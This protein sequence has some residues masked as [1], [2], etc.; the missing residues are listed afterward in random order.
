MGRYGSATR[1][2]RTN[3]GNLVKTRSHTLPRSICQRV[4][5]CLRRIE[6]Q[7]RLLTSIADNSTPNT[8]VRSH[9]TTSTTVAAGNDK[10]VRVCSSW[11]TAPAKNQIRRAGWRHG[12]ASIFHDTRRSSET[13]TRST[14]ESRSSGQSSRI[15]CC[16]SIRLL[17]QE[18][19]R[20]H[21]A[22]R[23]PRS[24]GR[25]F[26]SSW[27]CFCTSY[28]CITKCRASTTTTTEAF[29]TTD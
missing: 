1:F 25:A 23:Q 10:F 28:H 21:A 27:T 16:C 13:Q 22:C 18:G 19:I 26:S 17:S 2:V 29:I 6:A 9:R 15:K 5:R 3:T 7:L 24:L 12:H 4:P 11:S 14:N 8:I 20:N